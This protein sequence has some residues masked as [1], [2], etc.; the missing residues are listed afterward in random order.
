MPIRRGHR[1]WQQPKPREHR[2]WHPCCLCATLV[3]ISDSLAAIGARVYCWDC[4]LSI[5]DQHLLAIEQEKA[6][7]A[8]MLEP[9]E[10]PLLQSHKPKEP[11]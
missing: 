10:H 9:H 2:A 4:M 5:V 1:T 6:S 11:K 7:R 3:A 8:D